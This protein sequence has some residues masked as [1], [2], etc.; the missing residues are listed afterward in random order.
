MG[1]AEVSGVNFGVLALVPKVLGADSIK[2]YRPIA[3]INVIFKFIV[4]AY[5]I[6]LAPIAHRTIGR[7]QTTFIKGRCLYEGFWHYTRLSMKCG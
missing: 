7:L 3:L 5:T 4:K 1:M 2:Q 6:R